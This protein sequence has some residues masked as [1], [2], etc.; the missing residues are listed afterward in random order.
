M[1]LL[2]LLTALKQS[3]WFRSDRH[4]LH[5]CILKRLNSRCLHFVALSTRQMSA[6]VNDEMVTEIFESALQIKTFLMR[7]MLHVL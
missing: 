2:L 1:L 5:V 6:P 4:H 3:V 7:P